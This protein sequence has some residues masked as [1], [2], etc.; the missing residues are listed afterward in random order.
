MHIRKY[1][2]LIASFITLAIGCMANS[3]VNTMHDEL[4]GVS[5][6]QIAGDSEYVA[7]RP[8]AAQ[9]EAIELII[10]LFVIAGF[11]AIWA[12]TIQNVIDKFKK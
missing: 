1:W 11:I 7:I 5:V 4:S 12:P 6:S 8:T 9:V 10:A 2:R 3:V